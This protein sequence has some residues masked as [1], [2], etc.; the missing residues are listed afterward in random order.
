[1]ASKLS[2]L[3]VLPRHERVD[4]GGGVAIDVY[5]ISGEDLGQIIERYPNAFETLA[6]YTANPGKMHQNAGLMGAFLAAAQ[7]TDDDRSL[8][9]NEIVERRARGLALHAQIKSLLAMGRCTFPDG[10]NPFL[11]DFELMSSG[12]A[13]AIRVIV[14]ASSKETGISSL[15]GQKPSVPSSTPA[16]GN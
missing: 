8:L 4:F 5:G 7:R 6:E 15:N 9:G 12:T 16:S 13:E 1:M 3:D 11:K 2:L 14:Q 10:I